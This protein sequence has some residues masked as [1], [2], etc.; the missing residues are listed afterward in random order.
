MRDRPALQPMS[1]A[2]DTWH[3]GLRIQRVLRVMLKAPWNE[4]AWPRVKPEIAN[5]LKERRQ[6]ERAGWFN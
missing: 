5:A 1:A 6:I 2:D 3:P 4:E